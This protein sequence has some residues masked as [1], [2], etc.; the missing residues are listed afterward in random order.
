M[1]RI[2]IDFS[3]I[4]LPKLRTPE[5]DKNIIS[6]PVCC[7]ESLAIHPTPLIVSSSL[8]TPA[9]TVSSAPEYT[10]IDFFPKIIKKPLCAASE[11]ISS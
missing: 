2:G 3:C 1:S 5:S 7:T 4:V 8:K 6:V 9:V 10:N 11:T